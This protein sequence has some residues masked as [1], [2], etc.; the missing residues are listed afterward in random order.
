[1]LATGISL[2]VTTV[3][4][5]WVTTADYNCGLPLW[6]TTRDYQTIQAEPLTFPRDISK[7]L[8]EILQGLLEKEPDNRMTLEEAMQHPWL[9]IAAAKPRKPGLKVQVRQSRPQ[10]KLAAI[11]IGPPPPRCGTT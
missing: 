2:W 7:E 5:H 3:G 1:M 6:V 8:T 10:M 11:K 9:K 4:Y